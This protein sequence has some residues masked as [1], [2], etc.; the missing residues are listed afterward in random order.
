MFERFTSVG[1]AVVSEGIAEARRLGATAVGPEHLLVAVA[2][3]NPILAGDPPVMSPGPMF[4]P[5]VDVRRVSGDELRGLL[6][7]DDPEAS[8]LAAIGISLPQV[9]RALEESFGPDALDCEGRLPFRADAKRALELALREAVALRRRRIGVDELLLGLLREPSP[10][11][12]LLAR[13]DV[14]AGAVYDRLRKTL[15]DVG[16][17]V[18]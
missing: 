16:E 6:A 9:R 17:A 10:A 3:R 12:E 5:P 11:S 18:R 15:A 13:A 8:A 7:K 4:E 14:D 1:R 2:A